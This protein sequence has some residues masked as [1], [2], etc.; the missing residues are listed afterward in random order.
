[1]FCSSL[2]A[3]K[4]CCLISSFFLLFVCF[5]IELE[6]ELDFLFHRRLF[7]A[8]RAGH[9]S[10]VL[11][12]QLNYYV[13]QHGTFSN[14]SSSPLRSVPWSIRP[15]QLPLN[16]RQGEMK[17]SLKTSFSSVDWL[18]E[19][20]SDKC[21]GNSVFNIRLL[22][23][24]SPVYKTKEYVTFADQTVSLLKDSSTDCLFIYTLPT[25]VRKL[26]FLTG[27]QLLHSSHL[28]DKDIIIRRVLHTPRNRVVYRDVPSISSYVPFCFI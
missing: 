28:K 11:E 5:S 14:V 12:I 15:D 4:S 27:N 23:L 20:L 1:M 18:D 2:L 8:D 24:S 25:G 17:L 16:D 26:N 21:F 3:N 10:K 19:Q 9:S 7:L 22:Y 13:F 6:S